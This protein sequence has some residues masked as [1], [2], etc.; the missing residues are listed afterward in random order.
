M[1]SWH[2]L[3]GGALKAKCFQV[4][5]FW[6]GFRFRCVVA[7]LEIAHSMIRRVAGRGRRGEH[8]DPVEA[9]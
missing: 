8:K 3:A 2:G 6:H 1:S 5:M 7:V 4:F 9:Y